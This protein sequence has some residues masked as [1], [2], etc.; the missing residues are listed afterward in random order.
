MPKLVGDIGGMVHTT[1]DQ[2][3]RELFRCEG[4]VFVSIDNVDTSAVERRQG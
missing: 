1:Q 4:D 3:L 2:P